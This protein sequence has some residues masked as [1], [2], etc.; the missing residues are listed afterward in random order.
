[1]R[2][3][4]DPNKKKKINAVSHTHPPAHAR[5]P[6]KSMPYTTCGATAAEIFLVSTNNPASSPRVLI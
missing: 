1:M 6:K 2:I 5:M 4:R 3:S